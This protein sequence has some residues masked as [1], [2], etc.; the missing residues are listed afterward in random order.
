[1]KL[2]IFDGS[3]KT[4]AFINRLIEGLVNKG[5]EVYVMGFNEEVSQK[6]KGVNYIGLGSNQSYFKL[7][8]TSLSLGFSS[9]F[10]NGFKVLSYIVKQER[11]K[12]QKQNLNIVL[13]KIQPDIVH[14]QWPSLLPWLEPY[15]NMNI[16]KIVLSQRGSQT[17]INP[18]VD[19]EFKETLKMYYPH[20]DGI[21]SVSKAIQKKGWSQ[22]GSSAVKEEVVYT[23][24]ELKNLQFDHT[25]KKN[26]TL[27][28]LSVGRSHWVKGYDYSLK[29]L[30][31]LKEKGISYQYEIIGAY[32]DEELLF[33]IN[34]LG[35]TDEVS[36]LPKMSQE[37][38][39]TKMRHADLL[40]VPSIEEGI[41][42]VAVEAMA[43]GTPVISTDCGGMEELIEHNKEGWIVPKRKP[44][45]MAEAIVNF[46]TLNEKEIE[47]IKRNARKKVE[48]QH[49]EEKMISDMEDLY[50]KVSEIKI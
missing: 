19:S 2:I 25:S 50:K 22:G 34:D 8:K 3:F 20:L 47:E 14:L 42:N 12:L 9:G 33:L 29:A 15:F 7:I 1:M 28:I 31:I 39:Y 40:L 30:A 38:V 16:F 36:L 49:S 32:G 46:I 26:D 48:N 23:G 24:F 27:K 35:L 37:A 6:V 45:A 13:K 41:A 43:L 10:V 44:K 18:F 17:N 4:T 11:K 21:H 5:V